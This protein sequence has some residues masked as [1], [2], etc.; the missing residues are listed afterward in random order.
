MATLHPTSRRLVATSP[1]S[2][3]GCFTM[4]PYSDFRIV[5]KNCGRMEKGSSLGQS[6]T[7]TDHWFASDSQGFALRS[8]ATNGKPIA[9]RS[10]SRSLRY[11]RAQSSLTRLSLKQFE[12]C[13]TGAQTG[14]P[15]GIEG[16]LYDH[17]A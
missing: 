2:L 11:L 17:P 8:S 12:S 10:P 3:V 9:S 1:K 14:R 5:N 6:D 7:N 16:Y 15:T 13:S 4:K